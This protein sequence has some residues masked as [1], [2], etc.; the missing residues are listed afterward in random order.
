M[1]LIIVVL[2]GASHRFTVN[3]HD[4]VGSLKAV[5]QKKLGVLSHR[6]KL[7]FDNGHRTILNDDSKPI[8][9]YGLQSGSQLSLLVTEAPIQVFLKNE[10]GQMSTYEI[11]PDE[12]V[13]SFRNRVEHR[14]KVPASQQQLIHQ[15]RAMT[16]GKLSDYNVGNHSTIY[17]TLRLRGG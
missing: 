10:K 17:M 1:E 14:E 11:T 8:S 6:Q 15:S 5:I 3:P 12:T 7:V 4:T 16:D 9:S 13:S 2:D